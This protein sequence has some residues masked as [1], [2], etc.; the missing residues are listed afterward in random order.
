MC[1]M[2]RLADSALPLSGGG[3]A[4][5]LHGHTFHGDTKME[6]LMKTIMQAVA[7]PIY[8]MITR[9]RVFA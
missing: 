2:A 5:R 7:A 4:S 9:Y 6:S 1:L 8:K 3:L